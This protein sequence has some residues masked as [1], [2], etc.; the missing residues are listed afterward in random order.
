MLHKRINLKL[1]L[2][3]KFFSV[4]RIINFL[5][6]Y[7][8]FHLS[9]L[10]G[11]NLHAGF[12]ISISIEPT[13]SCNLRCPECPSG[14]RSFKRDT[15]MLEVN[16][17]NKIIK[18]I[19]KKTTYLTFY[20]QGEP[21]LNPN[22]SEMVKIAT[23]LNLYTSTST[24]AHYLSKENAKKTVE[25][26]L[27]QII[28]SIDGTTQEIYEKYRVGGNL[29]KVIEGTKNLIEQKKILQSKFPYVVFQF[30]VVRPNEHQLNDIK[31]LAE[32][33]EVDELRFKTAQV[34]DYENGNALIPVNE[35]YSRYKK[36]T[37]NKWH[38]KNQFK[39]ECW[40]MWSSCVI[41]WDGKI[42]PC[43]F[44]K[45]AKYSMG[46]LENQQFQEIWKSD[47]YNIFRAKLL[48]SRKDIDICKNCSE[49]TTV[50]V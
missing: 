27:H 5:K 4:Q 7:F 36:G 2:P 33:L 43:C 18:Q 30:L 40:R 6:I 23:D 39:N 8:S 32:A 11:L 50:H 1:L 42:V 41:T 34:Y 21:Y 9:K 22:F 10:F 14:L 46:N 48:K 25:S 44:D 45:D 47:E 35:S 28:I 20:F 13:T 31:L 29:N 3:I 16:L 15:G 12:P 49:G 24:N 38:L 19:D 17:F 37:D 26:G